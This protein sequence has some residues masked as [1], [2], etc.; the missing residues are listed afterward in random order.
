MLESEVMAAHRP[1]ELWAQTSVTD[2]LRSID[3]ER[4][5]DIIVLSPDL[6]ILEVARMVLEGTPTLSVMPQVPDPDSSCFCT[7]FIVSLI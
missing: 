1:R 6:I 4:E 3:R 7:R 5:R 2:Y